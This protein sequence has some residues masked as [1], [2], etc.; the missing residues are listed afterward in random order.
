MRTL[1]SYPTSLGG[2]GSTVILT[3]DSQYFKYLKELE[4]K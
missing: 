4:I 3:T 1:E 2:D